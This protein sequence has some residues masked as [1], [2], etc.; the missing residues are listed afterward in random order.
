MIK[1]S[2]LAST[3]DSIDN[4]GLNFTL[5]YGNN[6]QCDI[7]CFILGT[8]F[9]INVDRTPLF[10]LHSIVIWGLQNCT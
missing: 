1:H 5:G 9:S 3:Y 2:D 6:E 8:F 4:L 7:A 10:S